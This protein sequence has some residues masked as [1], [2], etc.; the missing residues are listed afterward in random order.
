M[1]IIKARFR[2]T[3]TGK[4]FDYEYNAEWMVVGDTE[5]YSS[6]YY[7]YTDG[8]FG[9]D[10]NRGGLFDLD[11]PCGEERIEMLSLSCDGVDLIELFGD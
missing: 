6:Q 10:C 7:Y 2:D 8:N 9:C 3:I 11:L 1:S 4:E 5:L